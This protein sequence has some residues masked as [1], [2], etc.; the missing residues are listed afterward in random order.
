MKV[1]VFTA[2]ARADPLE[3]FVKKVSELGYEAI[4]IQSV[5][6]YEEL[7]E[8][9][10]RMTR[11]IDIEK[12][13]KSKMSAH[14]LRGSVEKY[15]LTISA[16]SDHH[17]TAY[18]LHPNEAAARKA[19]E[20]TRLVADAAEALE[21]P[22]VV[23][24]SGGPYWGAY[25]GYPHPLRDVWEDQWKQF[26]EV[27]GPLVDYFADHSVKIAFEPHPGNILFTPEGIR[28]ALKELNRHSA[29]GLNFDPS[30]SIWQGIDVVESVKEFGDRIY[31]THAKDTEMLQAE[32]RKSGV[33]TRESF[34]FRIPGW[35]DLNWKRYITALR[36][37]GYDYVLSFEMEDMTM[38]SD[39]ALANTINF[40]KPLCYKKDM[41][42]G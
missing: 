16:L 21:V 34:R 23:G 22:V 18:T 26:R 31:H 15:G 20:R 28:R 13:A 5:R 33:L 3:K 36:E 30:H 6:T 1:G 8:D 19:R 10:S 2:I 12:V 35:G 9:P 7:S 42:V 4:E 40:L 11:H 24:F 27:W 38:T 14:D 37:V 41:R 32:V 39:D 17:S 29:L 25:Y